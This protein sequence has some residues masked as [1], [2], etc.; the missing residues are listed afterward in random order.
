MTTSTRLRTWWQGEPSARLVAAGALFV[1]L[2][3]GG[4]TFYVV[5]L[6]NDGTAHPLSSAVTVGLVFGMFT[7]FGSARSR[8]VRRSRPRVRMTREV[9]LVQYA[10]GLALVE[11]PV[12]PAQF[13]QHAERPRVGMTRDEALARYAD[14][15]ALVEDP[16]ERA[17]LG[18]VVDWLFSREDG[19][20]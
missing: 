15:L 8:L 18:E 13:R 16:V 14:R 6:G 9:P 10:G 17:E 3:T 11:G 12:E 20:R 19:T 5:N 4:V 7:A 2:V 1:A